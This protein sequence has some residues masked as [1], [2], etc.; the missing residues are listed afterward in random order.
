MERDLS[1]PET[2]VVFEVR[3][4][5]EG[6]RLD[7]FL[8]ERMPWRSRHAIQALIREGSVRVNGERLKAGRK[9]FDGDRVT[10]ELEP[11]D[12]ATIHH[13]RIPLTFLHEDDHVAVLDK[14]PG[15]I[16]HP[17]GRQLHNTLLNAVYHHYRVR[18]PDPAVTPRLGHRLDRD[19]SGVLL[20]SKNRDVRRVVQ[21]IFEAHRV[22]KEYFAIVH[23]A[24]KDDAGLI[25]E[26][27]DMQARPYGG[28]RMVVRAGGLPSRTRFRVLERFEAHTLVHLFPQ[29]GR[30]H[31]LRV[32][33][34]HLGHPIVCDTLY[35]HERELHC[36]DR[37]L[38]DRQ[39]LHSCR[40]R[41]PHPVTEET[42]DV[43]S[44]APGDMTAVL[45][46]LR[47]RAPVLP[48]SPPDDEAP[49]SEGE[50]R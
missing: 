22:E 27:I 3:P 34:A 9:V 17:A 35:G 29:T 5:L 50:T 49:P 21:E 16:V 40:L 13:D 2:D 7:L 8:K 43:H 23:G 47:D 26:P 19:T 46:A 20:V 41:L 36:G 1:V 11:I 37:T 6:R 14:Q 44:G 10:I 33:L 25:D 31:Q 28:T 24:M 42:L 18:R 30:T 12:P 39:A 15:I 38:I 48:Y 32:H 4:D 45:E